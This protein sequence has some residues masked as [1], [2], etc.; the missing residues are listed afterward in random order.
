M[1]TEQQKQVEAEF[2]KNFLICLRL[3]STTESIKQFGFPYYLKWEGTRD[4]N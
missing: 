1:Q 2:I 3:R 4:D